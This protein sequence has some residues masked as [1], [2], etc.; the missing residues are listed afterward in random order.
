MKAKPREDRAEA[1]HSND[2]WAMDFVHDQLATG[3]KM[4]CAVVVDACLRNAPTLDPEFTHRGEDVFASLCKRLSE[5]A[6]R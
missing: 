5:D 2:V 6:A 1:A 4:R 3:R